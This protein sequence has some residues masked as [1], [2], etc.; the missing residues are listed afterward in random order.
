MAERKRVTTA[1]LTQDEIAEALAEIPEDEFLSRFDEILARDRGLP[2]RLEEFITLDDYMDNE[3]REMFQSIIAQY[4]RPIERA[5]GRVRAGDHAKRTAQE[6]LDALAPI[7]SASVSLE[8]RDIAENL[9][10]IERPLADLA[11]GA[12]RRLTKREVA[13]LSDAWDRL[14]ARLRPD[15]DREAAPAP[16]LSVGALTGRLEGVT[17]AHVRSLRGA[18]LS[19]LHD[20]ASAPLGDLVAVTG[21]PEIVAERVHSF[22]VGAAAVAAS[23]AGRRQTD[24]PVPAGWVRVQVDSDVFRGAMT[25]EYARI[26]RYLEPILA[27][28]SEPEAP[29]PAKRPAKAAPGARRAKAP[30]RKRSS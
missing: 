29:A 22:A 7:L 16:A 17:A 9:R 4:I 18:G 5:V 11:G 20:V 19:T 3:L 6:G 1:P 10:Q 21:L 25:F 14:E 12:K 15:G 24:E 2:G 26:G 13:E 23:S 28:L 27:K 30:A 8:Y